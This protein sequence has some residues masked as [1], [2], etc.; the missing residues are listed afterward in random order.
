MLNKLYA[1][2]KETEQ[3]EKQDHTVNNL[4]TSILRKLAN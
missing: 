4:D 3:E 1:L 2:Y